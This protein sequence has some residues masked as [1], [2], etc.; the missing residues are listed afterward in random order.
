MLSQII[1]LK[2]HHGKYL[3]SNAD[4][5]ITCNKTEIKDNENFILR[6]SGRFVTI[7]TR[8]CKYLSAQASG[9]LEGNKEEIGSNE[10][11]E[12]KKT[13]D[14][15][16]AFK[17]CYGFYISAQRDGSIEVNRTAAK[18]FESF[19]ITVLKIESLM[20]TLK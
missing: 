16:Y 12:L 4:G 18:E 2:S 1:A 14:N 20:D 6:P 8:F 5:K 15:K 17:S 9:N 10:R 11:F 3:S 19:E 7:E 13:D